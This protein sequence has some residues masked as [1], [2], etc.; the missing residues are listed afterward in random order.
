MHPEL[1]VFNASNTSPISNALG[2]TQNIFNTEY[3]DDVPSGDFKNGVMCQN[4]EKLSFQ[5]NSI[6]LVITEDVFEHVREVRAGFSEVHRVLKPGGSHIFSIPFYFSKKTKHLFKKQGDKYV[7][8]VLP[9]EYHGD[10]IRGQIPA[11][12]RLGYDL[13]DSLEQ[14]GFQT[15]VHFSEF[16]EYRKF[17]TFNCYTFISR[18][19]M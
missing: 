5:N 15:S 14:I 17:A 11:F 19:R 18:K 9:I 7:P 10:P 16:H 8:S 12:H 13:F 2:N 1:K 3:F 4:L 6:D